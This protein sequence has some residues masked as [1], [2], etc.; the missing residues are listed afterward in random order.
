MKTG[1]KHG[2]GLWI[3]SALCL[4]VAPAHVLAQQ[5]TP[6]PLPEPE[7]VAP[8]PLPV[9]AP[10]LSYFIDEGGSPAGPFDRAELEARVAG[11]TLD[12]ETLV[13]TDGMADW[14]DAGSIAELQDVLGGDAAP[15]VFSADGTADPLDDVDVASEEVSESALSVAEFA[16]T[17]LQTTVVPLDGLGEGRAEITYVFSADG[18]YSMEGEII[19]ELNG[20][21][22][23]MFLTSEGV[24][25]V[26]D[27]DAELFDMTLDGTMSM[28]IPTMGMEPVAEP[29]SET[30]RYRR[31]DE[32]TIAEALTGERLVRVSP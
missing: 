9:E 21:P 32:D 26:Q 29:I 19:A 8:P 1:L 17:W 15:L 12:P 14:A 31:I 13:W 6:P 7:V 16:G 4:M 11:G 28:A 25:T 24:L 27:V 30:T 18:S 23:E 20:T 5:G 2:A 3:G 10:A 22:L